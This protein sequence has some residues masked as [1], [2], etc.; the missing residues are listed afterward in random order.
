MHYSGISCDRIE[1]NQMNLNG[2]ALT[3][4]VWASEVTRAIELSATCP[5]LTRLNVEQPL[6]LIQMNLMPSNMVLEPSR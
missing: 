4:T 1:W 6:L 2:V 5:V 3:A